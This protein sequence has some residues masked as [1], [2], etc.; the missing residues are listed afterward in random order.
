MTS[1]DFQ[2]R[3]VSEQQ[4]ADDPVLLGAFAD[5]VLE[6]EALGYQIT[7]ETNDERVE[8]VARQSFGARQPH[9]DADSPIHLRLL[10]HDVAEDSEWTSMQ[11]VLRGHGDY[12]YLAA[13]RASVVSGDCRSGFAFGFIS[14]RQAAHEEH[15]R[16]TMMQAPVL[17]MGSNRSLS[18]MHCAVVTLN[19]KS[20]MLRGR[21]NAGKTTLAYAALRQGFSLLCE[22]VGYAFPTSESIELRGIPWLLYLKPDAVRFFPELDGLDALERYN[23][24]KKILVHVGERF[25]KQVVDTVPPGP[26]VFVERSPSGTNTLH[27]IDEE[28]ALELFE[29]TRIAMEHRTADGI[30][31]WGLIIEHGAYRFEVGPDPLAAAK[32]LRDL[33]EG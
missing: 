30:D 4:P 27:P 29:S 14:D 23:G 9:T 24:E 8:R 2:H 21:P 32:V 10:V 3:I 18:A 19:G 16:S 12:F 13:S 6:L 25:P 11:P 5:R 15:L 20:I 31:I 7:V 1:V 33:C 22:D 26:V 28:E 17:W